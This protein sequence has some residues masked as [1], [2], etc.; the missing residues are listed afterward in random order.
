MRHRRSFDVGKFHC[1]L[2]CDAEPYVICARAVAF[3]HHN[4]VALLLSEH[5]Y[6]ECF[7]TAIDFDLLEYVNYKYLSLNVIQ[8]YGLRQ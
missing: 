6:N 7:A 1:V 5:I 4:C 2:I 3:E 8:F